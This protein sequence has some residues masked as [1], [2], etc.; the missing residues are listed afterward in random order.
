MLPVAGRSVT[1]TPHVDRHMDELAPPRDARAPQCNAI[2]PSPLSAGR[3]LN[4]RRGEAAAQRLAVATREPRRRTT[5]HPAIIPLVTVQTPSWLTRRSP[6][7]RSSSGAARSLAVARGDVRERHTL[8]PLLTP[9]ISLHAPSWRTSPL[10]L[11]GSGA[12]EEGP[13]P[14]DRHPSTNRQQP[15]ASSQ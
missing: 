4:I 1:P 3:T 12:W 14:A 13:G 2:A 7:A 8:P 6:L 9:L 10:S 5:L 15:R 11:G